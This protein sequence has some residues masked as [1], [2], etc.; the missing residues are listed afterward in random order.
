LWLRS[1][2]LTKAIESTND[3][4]LQ[5]V[6]VSNL[7]QFLQ[8]SKQQFDLALSSIPDSVHTLYRLGNVEHL[9]ATYWKED[10]FGRRREYFQLS[11]DHLQQ[12]KLIL[13]IKG[14]DTTTTSSEKEEG[15]EKEKEQEQMIVSGGFGQISEM[16]P[17]KTSKKMLL[18]CSETLAVVLCNWCVYMYIYSSNFEEIIRLTYM[19]Y[20]GRWNPRR[21]CMASNRN[22]PTPCTC[23]HG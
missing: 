9:L 2:E 23:E 3:K 20:S 19:L 14:L 6:L 16:K 8:F 4:E 15:K 11:V 10:D 21:C 17:K 5:K 1:L 18:E 7:L 22:K 12:A 13:E